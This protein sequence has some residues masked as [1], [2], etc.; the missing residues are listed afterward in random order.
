MLQDGWRGAIRT[1]YF[2]GVLSFKK[3]VDSP[4]HRAITVEEGKGDITMVEGERDITVEDGEGGAETD[5]GG[6]AEAAAEVGEV[7]ILK[8]IKSVTG[9]GVR[10]AL[11]S[12]RSTIELIQFTGVGHLWSGG[13]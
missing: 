8:F 3:P 12:F 10:F 4:L 13:L 9:D 2:A 7:E 6:K 1:S 5:S 11:L